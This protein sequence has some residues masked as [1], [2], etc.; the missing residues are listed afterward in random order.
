MED[1]TL[2]NPRQIGTHDGWIRT[3]LF[4]ILTQSLLVGDN[5]GH[6]KQYKKEN[7]SF[8]MVKDYGDMGMGEVFS[9]IQVGRFAIFGGDNRSLIAIDIYEQEVCKGRKKSPFGCTYSLQVFEGLDSNVYLFLGGYGPIYSSDA[10]D[11]L[12]VTLLYNNYNH[13][14]EVYEK[15]NQARAPLDQKEE[16]INFLNLKIKQLKSSLQKQVDQNQG[17]SNK[18][19]SKTKTSPSTRR[20]TLSQVTSKKPRTKLLFSSPKNPK[21]T[22]PKEIYSFTK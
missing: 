14:N 15:I 8:T 10:S 13:I 18:K 5:K 4:D 3:V 11:F 12:D 19:T 21:A 9:S 22:S 2:R 17:T 20:S 16:I 7:G 1:I 6:V